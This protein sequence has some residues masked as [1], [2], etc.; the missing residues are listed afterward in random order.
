[1]KIIYGVWGDT[2]IDHRDL[3]LEKIPDYPMFDGICEYESDE[4]Y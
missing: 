3:P 1:M 2:V 4:P